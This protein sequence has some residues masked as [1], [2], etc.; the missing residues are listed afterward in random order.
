MA[1]GDEWSEGW[2]MRVLPDRNARQVSEEAPSMLW[3]FAPFSAPMSLGGGVKV[4]NVAI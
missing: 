2:L 4:L 1:A 3:P